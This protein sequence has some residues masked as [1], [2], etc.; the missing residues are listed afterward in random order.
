[1]KN[2]LGDFIAKI[3][4]NQQLGMR[5]ISNDNG[6]WLV[7][8]TTSK[9][10]SVKSIMSP[11]HNFHIFTCTSADGKTWNKMYQILKAKHAGQQTVMVATT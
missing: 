5:V 11:N 8:F 7:N 9:H 3:I 1:M 10:F 6:V 4:S 2:L